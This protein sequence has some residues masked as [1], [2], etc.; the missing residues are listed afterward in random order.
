MKKYLIC[1][2]FCT[3]YRW[4][5]EAESEEEALKMLDDEEE[6]PLMAG[7]EEWLG[8]WDNSNQGDEAIELTEE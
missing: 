6:T 7:D 2:T 8:M 1:R 3:R 4:E 5:V